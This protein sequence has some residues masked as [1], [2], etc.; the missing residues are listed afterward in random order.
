MKNLFSHLFFLC[1]LISCSSRDENDNK[2][3][4]ILPKTITYKSSSGYT[5]SEYQYNGNKLNTIIA[6]NGSKS[7]ISYTNNF[8]TKSVTYDAS[9]AVISEFNYEY[10]N[11]KLSKTNYKIGLLETNIY[12]NWVDDNHVYI[13]DD[14]YKPNNAIDRTDVYFKNG[15]VIKSTNH[16]YY[17]NNYTIDKVEIIQIDTKNNPFKNIEGYSLIAFDISSDFFSQSNNITEISTTRIGNVNGSPLTENYSRNFQ[18]SYNAKNYP[19]LYVVNDS[20]G[21]SYT[22]EF[23]YYE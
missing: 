8:I 1:F 3:S 18:L 10:K 17:P 5:T 6:S 12:Y 14:K 20:F 9:G 4:I 21:N 19:Q 23:S 22:Y 16:L 11:N 15:N 2:N 13:E 7:I